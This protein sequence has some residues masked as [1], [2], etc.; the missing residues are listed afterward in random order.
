V[1]V[2]SV[3][4]VIQ[5]GSLTVAALTAIYGITA[6]RVEFVGKKRIDLAE[7][8]LVRFY[9]ARDVIRMIRSPFGY[10][11]EGGSRQ[12]GE[13][14]RAEE[15]QVLDNAYVA[16][17]RY[18]KHRELFNQLQSLR[19]RFMAQFGVAAVQ[20]FDDLDRILRDIFISARM[21][22]HYWRDQGH[23]TWRSEEEFQKHLAEMHQHEAVFW[24]MS[25][26]DKITPRVD[27]TVR[28]IEEIC[29]AVIR[30]KRKRRFLWLIPL[31]FPIRM[32]PKD[33]G[34][35]RRSFGKKTGDP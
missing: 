35:I 10:V 25:R 24:E 12:A 26:D 6:W 33:G 18:E 4:Q 27:Q 14:E 16:F 17:E 5:A 21:L 13:H 3:S 23:R 29:G 31:R 28:K 11:G 15:K 32:G 1:D 34:A 19:Y 22:A 7:E 30:Q 20:P 8:V 9:E 2:E